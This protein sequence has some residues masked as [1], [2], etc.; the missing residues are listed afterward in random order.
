MSFPKFLSWLLHPSLLTT[1]FLILIFQITPLPIG[2]LSASGR[3]VILSLVFV[4]TFLLP[5]LT[6]FILMKTKVI[7]SLEMHTIA[8]RKLPFLAATIYYLTCFYLLKELRLP[9]LYLLMM[10]GA[11]SVVLLASMINIFWKISIHMLG[12]GG[13]CGAILGIS[14]KISGD[15][16]WIFVLLILLSGLL[17]QARLSLEAHSKSQV[18]WGFIAGFFCEFLILTLI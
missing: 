2:Y 5:G 17:A 10:L 13:V 3:L 8:E 9:P 7:D 4:F 16:I 11:T 1:Y 12:I 14:Q 18:Y 15:L 6:A